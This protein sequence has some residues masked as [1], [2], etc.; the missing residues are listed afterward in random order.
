MV[1]SWLSSSSFIV[2]FCLVYLLTRNRDREKRDREEGKNHDSSTRR[3][4][5]KWLCFRFPFRLSFVW[6]KSAG[7]E[8]SRE[9]EA[10]N[11]FLTCCT[12]DH[13]FFSLHC[14]RADKGA[15]SMCERDN[16][17]GTRETGRFRGRSSALI[18]TRYGRQVSSRVVSR[19]MLH[20]HSVSY[21]KKRRSQDTFQSFRLVK[22]T[23][24]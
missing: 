1:S 12:A 21:V 7:G 5:R 14:L 20:I 16:K 11:F 19:S 23:H 22:N 10:R 6:E 24:S 8:R 3:R 15:E 17:P 4:R 9:R 18:I 2:K 13:M